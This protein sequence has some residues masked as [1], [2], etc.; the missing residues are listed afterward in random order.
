MTTD[1]KPNIPGGNFSLWLGILGGPAAW[2]GALQLGYILAPW[3]CHTGNLLPLYLYGVTFLLCGISAG[4]IACRNLLAFI[5]RQDAESDSALEREHFM[6]LLGVL[7]SA[8]F[9]LVILMQVAA[10]FI[11]GPCPE[12]A[13]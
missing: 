5:E 9:S 6:A 8:F 1:T 12:Q 10:V 4:R 11:V 7:M 3:A 2:L 13:K